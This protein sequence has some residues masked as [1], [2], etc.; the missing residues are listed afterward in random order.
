MAQFLERVRDRVLDG[1]A[2]TS[3]DVV[4]DLGTGTGL[5][6]LGALERAGPDGHVIF[7]DVSE[8]LLAE[9]RAAATRM[10]PRTAAASAR[11]RPRIS[12]VSPGAPWTSSRPDRC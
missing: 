6:G 3:G 7:S 10:G 2:I 8:E 9:T 4:L 5:I 1:G 12:R 11:R